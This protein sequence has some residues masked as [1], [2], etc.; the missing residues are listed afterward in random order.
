MRYGRFTDTRLGASG[1]PALIEFP[2]DAGLLVEPGRQRDAA[3]A[4]VQSVVLRI[5][6][7]FPAGDARLTFIDPNGA[8]RLSATVLVARGHDA[9]LVEGVFTLEAEIEAQLSALSHHVET[10]LLRQAQRQRPAAGGLPLHR[11]VRPSVRPERTLD[12]F[13]L[14]TLTETGSAMRCVHDRAPRRETATGASRGPRSSGA[15]DVSARRRTHSKPKQA[16]AS[17]AWRWT[18][19][20]QPRS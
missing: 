20:H 8:R 17:G 4:G 18:S 10:E 19:Y 7:A 12:P 13:V 2:G 16:T 9:E 3:I 15:C 11:C 1:I 6:A 5:L 14:F